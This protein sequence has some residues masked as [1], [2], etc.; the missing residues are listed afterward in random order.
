[1]PDCLER[2]YNSKRP[3]STGRLLQSGYRVGPA[4]HL[5]QRDLGR[6]FK[7]NLLHDLVVSSDWHTELT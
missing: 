1:V 2:F 5:P 7:E 3:R 4:E 6:P